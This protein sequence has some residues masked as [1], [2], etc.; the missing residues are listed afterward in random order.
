[1]AGVGHRSRQ[2]RTVG[3]AHRHALDLDNHVLISERRQ[4]NEG[5]HRSLVE[6]RRDFRKQ[7]IPVLVALVNVE[8]DELD[9]IGHVRVEARPE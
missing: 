6:R 5:D 2:T 7:T 1:M 3:A 9:E 8:T 4:R